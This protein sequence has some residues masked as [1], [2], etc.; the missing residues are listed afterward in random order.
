MLYTARCLK[1]C[2]FRLAAGHSNT[3]QK[4]QHTVKIKEENN[5]LKT[6]LNKEMHELAKVRA[7]K[8]A[9]IHKSIQACNYVFRY[10]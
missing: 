10:S 5:T 9:C 1:L 8:H 6:A 4:V 2:P 3:K 7:L